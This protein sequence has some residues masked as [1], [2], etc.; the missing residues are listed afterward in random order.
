[1]FEKERPGVLFYPVGETTVLSHHFFKKHMKINQVTN[2][3]LESI[4]QL[5][6]LKIQVNIIQKS[7]CVQWRV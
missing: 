7:Q 5:V 6:D 4:F 1:M 2:L 3:L